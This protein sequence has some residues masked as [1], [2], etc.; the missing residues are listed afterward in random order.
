MNEPAIVA[1]LITVGGA[2]A[3]AALSALVVVLIRSGRVLEKVDE[4]DRR[5]M[6]LEKWMMAHAAGPGSADGGD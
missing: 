3:I 1:A 4:I 6:L 5:T 2:I